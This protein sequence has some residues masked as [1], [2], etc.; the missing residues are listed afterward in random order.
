G[1]PWRRPAPP[2]RYPACGRW[3]PAGAESRSSRTLRRARQAR[4]RR[5]RPTA[6]CWHP[7]R[8]LPQKR[9]RTITRR[10]RPLA[11]YTLNSVV[12]L[13]SEEHTSELQSPD[14]LVCRLLLEKKQKQR[15]LNI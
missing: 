9:P 8:A 3:P 10:P 13:R 7:S 11:R 2:L 4:R 1:T 15:T 12:S 6:T 14:H 5:W